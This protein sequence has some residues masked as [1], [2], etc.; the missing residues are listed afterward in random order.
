[1]VRIRWPANDGPFC[2]RLSIKVYTFSMFFA[3]LFG[4]SK[5]YSYIL[6]F[7]HSTGAAA[8]GGL[9]FACPAWLNRRQCRLQETG[10]LPVRAWI[11]VALAF[12]VAVVAAILPR[13]SVGIEAAG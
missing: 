5:L 12:H 4:T 13:R 1:M 2:L 10:L 8:P 9:M 3:S 11:G 6:T 7:S